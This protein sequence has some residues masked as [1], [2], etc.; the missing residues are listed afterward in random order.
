DRRTPSLWNAGYAHW[1]GWDGA[2]DSLWTQTIRPI[3]D[4]REMASSAARVA[5]LLRQDGTPAR[6]Y[7]RAFGERPGGGEEP[8][9]VDAARALAAFQATLVSPRTPFDAFRDAVLAGDREAM[10]RYPLASQRGLRLF[11]GAGNCSTCHF[12]PRFTNGEFADIG[13]PFFI[14]SDAVDPG[15]LGGLA[16]LAR[17]PFNLAGRHNDDASGASGVRTRPVQRLHAHFCQLPVPGLR[18]AARAPALMH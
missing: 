18:H 16:T 13:I 15:R 9:L 11:I 1:F 8:P 4:P 5:G 17:N 2:G 14:G 7:Q 6:G 12:G 10:A 3:L